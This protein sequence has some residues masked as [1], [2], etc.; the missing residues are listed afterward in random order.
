MTDLD[1]HRREVSFQINGIER[2]IQT[3]SVA[4]DKIIELQVQISTARE[5]QMLDRNK[6]DDFR[7]D[8]QKEVRVMQTQIMEVKTKTQEVAVKVTLLIGAGVTV[9]NL[10]LWALQ[11]F[12]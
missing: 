7:R 10:G 2:W 12:L 9:M 3:A 4:L 11:R 1:Y 6:N 8:L 5:S